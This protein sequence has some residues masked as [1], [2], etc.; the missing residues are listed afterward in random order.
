LRSTT[1]DLRGRFGGV[2]RKHFKRDEEKLPEF[3]RLHIAWL[4]KA[5]M[6]A[7]LG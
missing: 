5:D 7:M 3:I 1:G 6:L 4:L 2:K